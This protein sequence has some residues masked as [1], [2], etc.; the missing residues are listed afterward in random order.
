MK[1]TKEIEAAK[2]VLKEAGYFTDNLWHIEDVKVMTDK[3]DNDSCQH[4]LYEAVTADIVME[5]INNLIYN[6]L[7]GEEEI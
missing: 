2:A 1:T 6:I 4:I 7:E 5:T 3:I